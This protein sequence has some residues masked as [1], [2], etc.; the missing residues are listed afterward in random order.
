MFKEIL[1]IRLSSIGDV[2]HCTP[3]ARSLKAAW[4]DC[5]ITWLVGEVSADLLKENPY[6]DEIIVW[7]REKFEKKLKAFQFKEA[8]K[9]WRELRSKLQ[10][11]DF[12]AALDI[13]GLFLT[14]MI[15][16]EVKTTRR[17]GMRDARELNPHFMTKTGKPLGKHITDKYLGVLPCLG[18]QSVDHRMSLS[19]PED[20]REFAKRFLAD[21]A[22][23]AHEKILILVIA[24]TWPTKNWPPAFFI[25]VVK[26]LAKD[27]K[28]IMC[29]SKADL[30][31]GRDIE[32]QAGVQ[33]VNAIGQTGLLEMAAL[34]EQ[35]SVLV[36]G[37][38]GPLHMAGA[39]GVPTVGIFGPTDP[40]TY[41]PIGEQ[42]GIVSSQLSCNYCHKQRCPKGEA[43][44]M[45]SIT[46]Q[47]VI[48]KVY[49]VAR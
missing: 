19:I 29:G 44:C 27:F 9:M 23:L 39:L 22:V 20:A 6:I 3:V 36:A 24:T 40:A 38:T 4:P 15:I 45:S 2:I 7:S 46:P 30:N 34:I 1:I 41:A 33:V 42:N 17:I 25:E 31:I 47:R 8:F 26:L 13:H 28:I 16:R 43:S 14:G 37:D 12:Y 32:A 11:Q 21:H 10:K 18:I 49:D 35:A 48:Q 5:R